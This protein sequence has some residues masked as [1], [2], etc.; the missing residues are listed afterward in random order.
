MMT[1][2]SSTIAAYDGA[3]ELDEYRRFVEGLAVQSCKAA[4]SA[5]FDGLGKRF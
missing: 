4:F 5:C 2:R 1:H 3:E